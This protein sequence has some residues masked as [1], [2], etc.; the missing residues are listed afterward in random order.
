MTIESKVIWL[1]GEM[2]PFDQ[3]NVHLLSHTLHYGLW[4]FEGIRSYRQHDGGGGI[5]KLEMFGLEVTKT[6]MVH[7]HL[8]IK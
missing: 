4:A 6:N 8:N 3:A 1:D 7:H 2:V 5:F